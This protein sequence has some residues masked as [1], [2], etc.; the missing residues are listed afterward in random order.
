MLEMHLRQHGS[1]YSTCG[2]FTKNKERIQ[3][4]EETQDSRYIQRIELV[5]ACLKH[6]MTYGDFR[7]LTWRTASV[8]Y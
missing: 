8:S 4:F 5:K 7:D 3:K 6:Y 2:P 1:T